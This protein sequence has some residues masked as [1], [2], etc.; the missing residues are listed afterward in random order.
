MPELIT[1]MSIYDRVR[2]PD[3]EETPNTI[4]LP[5]WY[6]FYTYRG[7][8]DGPLEIKHVLQL[9]QK[10]GCSPLKYNSILQ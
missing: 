6:I 2:L 7:P 4:H 10:K 9:K 5:H 8:D 3:T 1:F